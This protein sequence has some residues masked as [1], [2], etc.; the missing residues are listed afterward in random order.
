MRARHAWRQ[1]ATLAA[2]IGFAA[3]RHPGEA[4]KSRPP[5]AA[6]ASAASA[7]PASSA[8]VA[9]A[10]PLSESERP[11]QVPSGDPPRLRC[12]EARG[13]VAEVRRRLPAEPARVSASVFADLWA[14]W[15]DPHGLWSAAPDS[16]LADSAHARAVALLAELESPNQNAPCPVALALAVESKHWVDGL[17]GVFEQARSEAPVVRFSSALSGVTEPAFEDELVAH[18]ARQLA[19]DLGLRVGQF[20]KAAPELADA[21]ASAALSRFFPDLSADQWSEVVLSAA[22]RAYV[23]AIDPHGEW[24]PLEEE[25]AL[26][27]GDPIDGTEPTLWSDMVRTALG[28][29]I[30][31]GPRPPLDMDDLVLSVDGVATAGLSVEQIEQLAR[32]DPPEG[33]SARKVRVLRG[34]GLTPLDLSI[35]FPQD[36]AESGDPLAASR[37]RYG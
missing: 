20:L 9:D 28:A 18:P 27:E 2:A 21:P 15:F 33:Q 25:W 1:L 11:L 29:R 14:D 35:A 22:V 16:P 30:V 17:R 31:A 8:P 4:L 6:L 26:F 23:P 5:L 3:C 7:Q 19:A 36:S 24:A 32:V 13:I 12:A 37:V 34:P 10:P